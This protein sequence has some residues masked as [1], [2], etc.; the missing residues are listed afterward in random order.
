MKAMKK[1]LAAMLV[2]ALFVAG[3]AGWV[4]V[5]YANEGSSTGEDCGY[6]DDAI[7]ELFNQRR[8][9]ILEMQAPDEDGVVGLN[10]GTDLKEEFERIDNELLALGVR[11]IDPSNAE[12]IAYLKELPSYVGNAEHM[13]ANGIYDDAPDLSIIATSYDMY[14]ADGSVEPFYDGTEAG[15]KSYYYRAVAVADKDVGSTGQLFEYRKVKMLTPQEIAGNQVTALLEYGF[16]ILIDE[17]K[18]MI[19]KNP[20]YQWTLGAFEAFVNASSLYA[21]LGDDTGYTSSY[22][23][24]TTMNYYYLYHPDYGWK[25]IA[26]SGVASVDRAD[27]FVGEIN[28]RRFNKDLPESENDFVVQSG[29][30]RSLREFVAAYVSVMDTRPDYFMSAWFGNLQ[31]KAYGGRKVPFQPKYAD[32]PFDLLSLGSGSS[33]H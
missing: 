26:S 7:N 10:E 30:K 9:L 16:G 33:Y 1:F 12:D 27:R 32:T 15:K 3:N 11:K 13:R 28:G 4:T 19:L 23:S 31:V 20:V 29:S 2:V 8:K 17:F 21:P 5:T 25:L 24:T 18:G 22:A 6:D 14:V